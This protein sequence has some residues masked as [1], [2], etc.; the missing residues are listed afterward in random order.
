[1]SNTSNLTITQ[2]AQIVADAMLAAREQKG[3]HHERR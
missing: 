3:Q 2:Y 1:M